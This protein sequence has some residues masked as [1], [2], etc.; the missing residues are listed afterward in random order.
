MSKFC[1]LNFRPLLPDFFFVF[2]LDP[3][4]SFCCLIAIG[5]PF[6]IFVCSGGR[7]F[8]L[9]PEVFFAGICL[10]S[11]AL[12]CCFGCVLAAVLTL[13]R[14]PV[15]IDSSAEGF[16]VFC[17]PLCRIGGKTPLKPDGFV[18]CSCDCSSSFLCLLSSVVP[19]SVFPYK[20][21]KL[22]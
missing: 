2:P 19:L 22:T 16:R 11:Y 5:R 15:F 6:T 14:L 7:T 20:N 17:C 8:L 18:S 12:I 10:K 13:S 9:K 3:C 1:G 4:S 21:T